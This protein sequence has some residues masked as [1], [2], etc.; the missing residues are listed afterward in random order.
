M[1]L[2]LS[3]AFVLAA[4]TLGRVRAVVCLDPRSFRNF[5]SDRAGRLFTVFFPGDEDGTNS[6][7]T[8]KKKAARRNEPVRT[9][10]KN[11]VSEILLF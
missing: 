2:A 4:E 10:T 11:S 6:A 3:Y 1:A 5:A 8:W 7:R 9:V